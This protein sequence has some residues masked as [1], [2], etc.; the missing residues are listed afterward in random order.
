MYTFN[1]LY[2]IIIIGADI[3]GLKFF[4]FQLATNISCVY[5]IDL[6]VLSTMHCRKIATTADE[7]SV[8]YFFN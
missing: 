4:I 2:Y 8:N 7:R 5:V 1:V 3:C 6:Y